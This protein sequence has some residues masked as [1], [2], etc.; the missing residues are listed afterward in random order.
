M[1]ALKENLNK[2]SASRSS[3]AKECGKGSFPRAIKAIAFGGI[4][5]VGKIRRT[6]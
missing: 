5:K 6:K 4:A 3:K 2:I 1:T